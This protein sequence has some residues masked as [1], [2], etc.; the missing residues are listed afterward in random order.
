VSETYKVEDVVCTAESDAA[1]KVEGSDIGE[2]TW[3]PKSQIDDDSE[4]Y[5]KGTEGTLIVTEWIAKQKGWL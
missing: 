4:V 2:P 5:A 3:V 1:I